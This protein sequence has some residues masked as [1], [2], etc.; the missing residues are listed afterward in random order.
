[1]FTVPRYLNGIALGYGLDGREFKS[2]E[3]LGIFLFNTASRPPA[4]GLTQSP[5]QWIPGD[6]SLGD[7]R[8]GC[9]ADR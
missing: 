7:K 5:I 8:P 3:G 2:R 9:E 4:L 1:M 6:I